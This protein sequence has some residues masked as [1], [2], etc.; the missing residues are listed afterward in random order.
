MNDA[1]VEHNQQHFLQ[2][3]HNG[4]SA[5]IQGSVR[6][7]LQPY[8]N[9]SNITRQDEAFKNYYSILDGE[10]DLGKVK[11]SE[12]PFYSNLQLVVETDGNMAW[13]ITY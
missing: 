3:F 8:D 4:T 13:D 6:D 11:E 12:N 5:A 7:D 2:H 1:F 9:D 10:Y